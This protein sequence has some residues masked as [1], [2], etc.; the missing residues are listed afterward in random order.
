MLRYVQNLRVSKKIFQC[1]LETIS[2]LICPYMYFLVFQIHTKQV[3]EQCSLY[4]SF[5]KIECISALMQM[6]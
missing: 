2:V 1:W 6:L 3:C 5:V 4:M